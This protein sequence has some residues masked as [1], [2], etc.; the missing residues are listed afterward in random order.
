M[1]LTSLRDVATQD[2]NGQTVVSEGREQYMEGLVER[3][4]RETRTSGNLHGI[5]ELA[6]VI[7][8]DMESNLAMPDGTRFPLHP[9]QGAPWIHPLDLRDEQGRLI[10]GPDMTHHIA[11]DF[12][13]LPKD[14]LRG[15]REGK[16]R[17]ERAVRKRMENAGADLLV[18]DHYMACIDWIIGEEGAKYGR[19]L[20]IHPAITKAGHP[21]AFRGKSPTADAIAAAQEDPHTR[22]GATLHIVNDV[23]D[24]GPAIAISEGTPVFADDAPQDLRLRNYQRAKLPLFIAGMR[25]YIERIYPHLDRIDLSAL[26]D[27]DP[28]VT[29]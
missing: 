14:D 17:F 18:S 29:A 24:D 10:A 12:R 20:N 1:I 8:D 2:R 26:V 16:E 21:Y 6:G 13:A 11:S 22:T 3:V 27:I 23:I 9:R 15:R 5:L 25:H 4:V 28:Y 19:V 7:I